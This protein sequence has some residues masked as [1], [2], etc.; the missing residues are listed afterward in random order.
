MAKEDATT[1]R[2]GKD[3]PKVFKNNNEEDAKIIALGNNQPNE[4]KMSLI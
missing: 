4:L 1:I 3:Q 2:L